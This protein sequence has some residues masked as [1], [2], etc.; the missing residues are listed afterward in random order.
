MGPPLLVAVRKEYR[1][2]RGARDLVRAV[3]AALERVEARALIVV[4][5]GEIFLSGEAWAHIATGL[6]MKFSTSPS[7]AEGRRCLS[8]RLSYT[9]YGWNSTETKEAIPLYAAAYT[10]RATI[11]FH[12]SVPFYSRL[13][14]SD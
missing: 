6:G 1:P 3:E 14:S 5:G 8:Y 10:S 12:Q 9:S 4:E 13:L 2:R 7:Q 11:H